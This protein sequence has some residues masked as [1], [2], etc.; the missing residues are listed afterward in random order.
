MYHIYINFEKAID[1]NDSINV[2]KLDHYIFDCFSGWKESV[3]LKNPTIQLKASID[4]Q[5]YTQMNK[6]GPKQNY[7]KNN[8][9]T[10]TGAQSC[11]WD[12][13]SYLKHGF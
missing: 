13:S 12:L 8:V 10:D 7:C 3:S 2:V 5:A 4:K 1:V 6:K 9:V 11:L